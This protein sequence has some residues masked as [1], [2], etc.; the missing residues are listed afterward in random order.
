[1]V[2]AN[3]ENELPKAA[4]NKL[5]EIHGK[6]GFFTSFFIHP[7][8]DPSCKAPPTLSAGR[9]YE[10]MVGV[11]GS[12]NSQAFP[13]C[14]DDYSPALDKVVQVAIENVLTTF[15]LDLKEGES[16]IEVKATF[17]DDTTEVVPKSEY[18]VFKNSIFFKNRE[19]LKDIKGFEFKV[20]GP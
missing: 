14:L 12:N 11:L 5:M 2:G 10:E 20:W 17:L 16:V 3:S 9:R 19:I 15:N 18:E 8:N 4:A 1:M 13:V 7:S 6:N